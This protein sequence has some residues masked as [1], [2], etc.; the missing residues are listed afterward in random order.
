M[1][2]F[3]LATVVADFGQLPVLPEIAMELLDYLQRAD[4]DTGRVVQM[5]SQDQVLA[6][7]S[8]RIANSS[9]YGLQRKV[10][11]INDAIVV[12]GLRSVHALV[13]T[14]AITSQFQSIDMAGY[15]QRAFWLHSV[16]AALCARTLGHQVGANPESAFTAGLIHDIGKLVLAAR[17]PEQ[18]A[19]V[20][21]YCAQHDCLMIEAE[22]DVLG[23]DHAQIGTALAQRWN[24]TAEISD[25]VAWHHAPEEQ[26]ASSLAGVIHLADV[27][28]HALNF[29]D[30]T[31]A[32]VPRLSTVVWN[33]LGLG[34]QDFKRLL[35]EVDAQF[36]DADLLFS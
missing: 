9:F 12:L 35:A 2:K 18:F 17:F 24:F 14:A 11:T 5:L 32:Q 34:W 16:G 1:N 21:A 20:L 29:A 36:K 15:N 3:T 10:A 7:K 6:A 4:V 25:A 8:L 31:D 26:T 23:F 19:S 33:R 30:D 28:A 13:T 27:M 22:H